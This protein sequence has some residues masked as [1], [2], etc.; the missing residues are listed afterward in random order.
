MNQTDEQDREKIRAIFSHYHLLDPISRDARR[1]IAAS[2]P[3]TQKEIGY[4]SPRVPRPLRL[5]EPKPEPEAEEPGERPQTVEA[6]EVRELYETIELTLEDGERVLV[7]PEKLSLTKENKAVT[8]YPGGLFTYGGERVR[9][10][11]VVDQTDRNPDHH[12]KVVIEL[13]LGEGGGL[14]RLVSKD[15]IQE[16]GEDFWPFEKLGQEEVELQ[17]QKQVEALRVAGF[18]E[19]I[20][21]GR[22]G[23]KAIDGNAYPV[24][25]LETVLALM[26]EKQELLSTKI[27]QG[28]T[29]L[30][31]V[32]FGKKLTE[33]TDGVSRQI[34]AH[35]KANKLF[36][37]KKDPNN[38]RE[39]LV[40]LDLDESQPL[41]VWDQ[42]P[43]ADTSGNMVYYPDQYESEHHGGKKKQDILAAPGAIPGWD[44]LLVEDLPNIPRANQ[45]KTVGAPGQQ[46]K[47]PEAGST[48]RQY[49]QQQ[50]AGGAYENEEFLTPEAWL[51]Y[52]ATHLEETDQVIDDY[53]GNGSVRYLGAAWFPS[54]GSVPSACWYRDSRRA[55]LYGYGP[56]YRDDDCGVGSAVR[57]A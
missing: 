7:K 46:R 16:S 35:K 21:G 30:L 19:D 42:Y 50:K 6:K 37:T 56:G 31:L 22:E 12:G 36:A 48:P 47:Q 32:P 38:P 49:L 43:D 14:H 17:Y 52:F 5:A 57:V 8:L 53:Q 18:I 3:L 1:E 28:F 40:P 54:S 4:L 11:G 44:I 55:Y 23:I 13:E 20:G 29:K 2:S 24:P 51:T 27:E 39:A 25:E 10:K 41:W 34:L 33:L 26:V 15:E 9:F 45:G